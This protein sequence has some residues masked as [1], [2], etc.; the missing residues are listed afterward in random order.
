MELHVLRVFTD[1]D[2]RHG[3]PLGVV[4]DGASVPE[5][6]RQPLAA[7][8]GYSETV[9][10]DDAA[11]GAIRIFTPAAELEFAGHPT[12]GT[13]CL[14]GSDVLRPPAGDVR[15]RREDAVTW[16]RARPEWG[17]DFGIVQL[18]SA[19]EVEALSSPPAGLHDPAVW[20]H[21]D[22]P[23]GLV[24]MRVFPV[25]LGIREDE[26]TGAAAL[27]LGALL[28]RELTIRQG[29]GSILHVRPGG[30]GFVEV[31]GRVVVEG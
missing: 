27:R 25:S 6:Q 31:G 19:A 9:F 8:L 3:N 14:L 11:R 29:R 2:G 5:A 15:V 7:A 17:P 21:E 4:L 20:A 12:V 22:E 10:V 1:A 16:V 18:A 13:A 30:D 28:G 26:A 23:A 24:R